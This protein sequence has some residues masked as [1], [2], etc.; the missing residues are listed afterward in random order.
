MMNI[1]QRREELLKRKA[2]R[3]MAQGIAILIGI[4]LALYTIA[5]IIY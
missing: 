3:D 5:E 1:K 4:T 2:R